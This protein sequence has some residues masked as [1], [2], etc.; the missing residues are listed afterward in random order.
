MSDRQWVRDNLPECAS[1]AAAFKAEFGDVR[2]TYASENG[3]V[4][5]K[6]SA[7]PVGVKGHEQARGKT[8]DGCCHL[9]MR[10]VTPDGKVRQRAC[11]IYRTAANRCADWARA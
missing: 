8:C 1:V 11:R 5:G 7:E 2:L 10:L 3:H 9:F 6:E 4:L